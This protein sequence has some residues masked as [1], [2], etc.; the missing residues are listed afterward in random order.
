MKKFILIFFLGLIFNTY[1]QHCY[2]PTASIDIDINNIRAKLLNGGDMWWDG[3]NSATYQ[4]PKIDTSLGTIPKNVLFA[5]ALWV[6]GIDNQANLKLAGQTFRNNGHEFW[7]GPIVFGSSTIPDTE[8]TKFDRFF[9]ILRTELDAH[10]NAINAASNPLSISSMATNIL[11]WPA[12]GNQYLLTE[13][14]M[15]IVD[16]LAPFQDCNNN[17][18]YDPE[19]GDFPLMKGDQSIFWVINDI[20]NVHARSGGKPLGVEI[21]CLAY[22]YISNDEVND[23]TFYDYKVIKKT[24]G[25]LSDFYFSKFVDPDIGDPTNDFIG[26]DTTLNYGFCYNSDNSFGVTGEPIAVTQFLK[27]PGKGLSSFVGFINSAGIAHS[28][29]LNA[30]GFRLFQEGFWGD[31]SPITCG[32]NGYGGSVPTKFLFHG[33]PAD[34]SS[35]GSAC[36]NWSECS[37]PN[38]PTDKRYIMN[39]GPY[40]LNATEAL[41]FT[42]AV[43][44]APTDFNTY[45]GCPDKTT[46]INPVVNLVNDFINTVNDN[47]Y[48]CKV[49]SS[50]IDF[51]DETDLVSIYPNPTNNILNINTKENFEITKLELYDAKGS[52]IDIKIKDNAIDL[53]KKAKG[54]YTLKIYN[55]NLN[56]IVLKKF[57]LR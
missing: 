43:M 22:A 6:S 7:S 46:L 57:V 56:K 23:A 41:D 25:N 12:K 45:N 18:I 19:N 31:G 15:E 52:L 33:N 49:L 11:E 8:C 5:G 48:S 4:Y 28:D 27:T 20:G 42:I 3:V 1:S 39:S 34:T 14:N 37:L 53:T 47:P 36:D 9:P 24:S 29:P 2:P 51:N 21:Q 40:T 54:I 50:V 30:D 32:G 38:T 44:I 26:C 16:D 10:I 13:Y 17:E 55:K 35:G